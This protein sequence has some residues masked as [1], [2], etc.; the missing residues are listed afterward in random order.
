MPSISRPRPTPRALALDNLRTFAAVA[1]TLSFRA[2][3]DELHLT[4]SAVSRR[5]QALEVDLGLPLF[6]RDTRKVEL[7]GAGEALLRATTQALERIDQTV[8]R[9]RAERARRHVSVT[10]FGT[11]ATS[12]LLPRLAGFQDAH[13]DID[14]RIVA[15]DKLADLDDPEIDVALRY[16]LGDGAPPGGERM[17]GEVVTPVASPMLMAM[18]RAGHAPALAS[19]ADLANHTLLDQDESHGPNHHVIWRHWL[20]AQGQPD[21][22][23]RRRITLN[24]G[25][26]GTQAAAAGQGVAIARLGVMHDILERGELVEPFGPKRRLRV[27]GTYWILPLPGAVLRPDLRLFLAWLREQ[28]AI[29]RAALG[30]GADGAMHAAHHRRAPTSP[31]RKA[32]RT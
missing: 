11:F 3:A 23:P 17:F 31:R 20:A 7:T 24:Y 13:P 14:I 12:W 19:V 6:A 21:L 8:A 22:E 10:T 1:R 18:A 26:Q 25:H 27:P 4:Q 15:N 28:A 30:E 2:S 32:R 16:L 5:V 9:L 29:T